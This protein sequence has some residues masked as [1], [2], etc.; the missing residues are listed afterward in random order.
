MKVETIGDTLA[1]VEAVALVYS[2]AHRQLKV[3][4]NKAGSGVAFVCAKSGKV[5]SLTSEFYLQ[6]S[7]FN[8]QPSHF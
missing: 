8:L 5:V 7:A 2:L 4:T 3:E 1:K 6:L